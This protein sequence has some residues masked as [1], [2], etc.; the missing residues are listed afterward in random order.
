MFNPVL[1]AAGE[2]MGTVASWSGCPLHAAVDLDAAP[3]DMNALITSLK[4]LDYD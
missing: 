2:Q 4:P 3:P 1:G